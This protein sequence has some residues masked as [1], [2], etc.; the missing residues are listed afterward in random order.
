LLIHS[1]IWSLVIVNGS[2]PLSRKSVIWPM[3][4]LNCSVRSVH[5]LAIEYPTYVSSPRKKTIP[6]RIASA[7][8]SPRGMYRARNSTAGRS[9]AENTNARNTAMKSSWT[10]DVA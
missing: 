7:V 4:V 8:A 3:P 2:E 10:L 9:T 6:P 1:A 5:W